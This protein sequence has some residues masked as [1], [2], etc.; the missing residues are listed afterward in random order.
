[1]E[2]ALILRMGVSAP[3]SFTPRHPANPYTHLSPSPA[4]AV[5]S[6]EKPG[7]YRAHSKDKSFIWAAAAYLFHGTRWPGLRISCLAVEES[8]VIM[9]ST[10]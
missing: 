6:D 5:A 10:R 2:G 1:M 9:T 4:A 3:S 8:P 7:P